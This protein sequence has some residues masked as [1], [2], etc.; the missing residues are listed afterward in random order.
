MVR[1]F[2]GVLFVLALLL[3]ACGNGPVEIPMYRT[4]PFDQIN[5][6]TGETRTI[7]TKAGQPAEV[8]LAFESGDFIAVDNAVPVKATFWSPVKFHAYQSQSRT[9]SDGIGQQA[10]MEF[11]ANDM[12]NYPVGQDSNKIR[13]QIVLQTI[14]TSVDATITVI[15]RPSAC[16]YGG[17]V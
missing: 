9:A 2:A 11:E 17:H 1:S 16:I 7:E 13:S 4:T 10:D 12:G 14:T 3:T 5:C 6:D 8:N 15:R